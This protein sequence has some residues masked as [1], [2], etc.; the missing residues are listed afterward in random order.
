[1]LSSF[2]WGG[3]SRSVFFEKY[4]KEVK[5][6]GRNIEKK[7]LVWLNYEMWYLVNYGWG[8]NYREW[9]CVDAQ[10][11]SKTK[12]TRNTGNIYVREK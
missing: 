2:V 12:E 1:L 8:D 5:M 7:I 6:L 4:F 9:I 11:G 3:V 10:Y